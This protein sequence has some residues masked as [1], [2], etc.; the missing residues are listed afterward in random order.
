[1]N[2]EIKKKK[3]K[4][5]MI[6]KKLIKWFNDEYPN[7]IELL[8]II[9]EVENDNLEGILD[10]RLAELL[11]NNIE[12]FNKMHWT[13]NNINAQIKIWLLILLKTELIY[14][15]S[16]EEPKNYYY[17]KIGKDIRKNNQFKINF[18]E[19]ISKLKKAKD[20]KKYNK[21]S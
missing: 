3:Y 9:K 6:D 4:L 19:Q 10:D 8:E 18:M 11:K 5:A 16:K 7:Y 2:G 15:R 13:I 21:Q 12:I 1:M 20:I 14:C 17:A